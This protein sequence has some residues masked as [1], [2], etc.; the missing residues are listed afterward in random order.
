[1]T[2]LTQSLPENGFRYFDWN[3]SSSDA[4]S[5]TTAE[6][7]YRNVINGISGK[8]VSVVLQHD[9]KDFSVAAVERII[10]WALANGY[11]FLPLTTDS[12]ACAHRVAN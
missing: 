12:P 6:E 8:K 7:V 4:S 11:T 2:Q 1:M 10:I 5:A 3:V 9:I